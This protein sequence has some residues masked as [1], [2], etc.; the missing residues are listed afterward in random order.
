MF[1]M[2]DRLKQRVIGGAVLVTAGIIVLPMVLRAPPSVPEGD[3]EPPVAVNP[4]S[5]ADGFSSRIVPL[6]RS[7]AQSGGQS[8]K[9][10]ASKIRPSAN[11]GSAS[12]APSKA[13]STPRNP[14]AAV[15]KPTRRVAVQSEA[16]VTTPPAGPAPAPLPQGWAVQLGAFSN[17][18]NA[19]ALRERI[20]AKGY[21][22]FVNT[23]TLDGKKVTRVLVGPTPG[24]ARAQAQLERLR[25]DISLRGMLVRYPSQ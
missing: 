18:S 12:A 2:N 15:S 21:T 14:P 24:K 9:V 23:A 20:K 19:I 16:Q 5:R 13:K 8:P 10:P 17:A 22:A 3:S 4:S 6:V 11:S 7:G 25:R 1:R